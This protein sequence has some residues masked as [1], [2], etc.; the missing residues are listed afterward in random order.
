[1]ETFKV[2]AVI[3]SPHIFDL[4]ATVDKCCKLIDEAADGGAKLVAFPE[5]FLPM[6]PWWIWMAVNNVDRGKL[7]RRLYEQSVDLKGEQFHQIKMK[8]RERGAFVVVGLNEL[9]GGTI[10]NSQAFIDENGELVGC[11]RKLIPTGE[12]RTLWGRGDGGDLFVCETSVGKLGALICYENIMPLSRYTLYSMG[13][14]IHVANWPGNEL[15]SQPRD[16]TEIIKTTSR[17]AAIE[18]QMYVVA[19]S[20]CIGEEEVDFYSKL[21]PGLGGK[22]KIGGGIAAVY[23][24]FGEIL[25]IVENKEGIAFADVDLSKTSEAKHL[26]DIVGHYAR[27]DVTRV[28]FRGGRRIPVVELERNGPSRGVGGR[29]EERGFDVGGREEI[30]I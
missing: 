11:R 7:Y 16:R 4:K 22:L 10:Y 20:S 12:E 3:A 14:Q 1:M 23:S 13:E 19:S 21:D 9:D 5:T 24:P 17:F 18:G 26:I 30:E 8:A 28:I 25:D 15:K 2:A 6:Y 29:S 27:P